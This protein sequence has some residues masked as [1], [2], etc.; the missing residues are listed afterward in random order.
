MVIVKAG[1]KIELIAPE[2][3]QLMERI[4]RTCYKSEDRIG[5]D[6]A[7]PF[8][9]SKV[10]LGHESILEHSIL[11]VLFT[12][13]RGISH[14]IVRHRQDHVDD[15]M[16][17]RQMEWDP[18][19]TQESTR[20]VNYG[21]AEHITVVKP[22][23]FPDVPEG[24]VS[25]ND[26]MRM[27]AEGPYEEDMTDSKVWMCAM[28]DAERSYMRMLQ[29]GS[30]AQIARLALPTSAK[31]ELWMSANFREWRH[32]LKLRTAKAAHPQMREVAIPLLAE[33]KQRIPVLFD[34]LEV[35]A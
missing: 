26:V 9:K 22:C 2:G 14:E 21:K 15:D 29:K 34:D 7:G 19:V 6:T 20:Y 18:G 31:T 35:A 8:L 25:Y 17:I 12:V 30:K 27:L 11:T 5:E 13:D 33:V 1:Y 32:F 24:E 23:V 16:T 28:L 4:G 3:L 10:E